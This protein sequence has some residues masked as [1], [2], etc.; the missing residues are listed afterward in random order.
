MTDEQPY[1]DSIELPPGSGKYS[2]QADQLQV[3]ELA[4][5][6]EEGEWKLRPMDGVTFAEQKIEA[7]DAD[8][9][10]AQAEE[11]MT[12]FFEENPE[13]NPFADN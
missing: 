3:G 2:I 13:Q 4:P 10:V 1:I 8:D 9:A 11:W 12:A 7:D 6:D 5:T